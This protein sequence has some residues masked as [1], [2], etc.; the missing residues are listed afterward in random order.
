MCLRACA[1]LAGPVQWPK[2]EIEVLNLAGLGSIVIQDSSVGFR[3]EG[4]GLFLWRKNY[5]IWSYHGVWG[6]RGASS[7]LAIDEVTYGLKERL[8]RYYD[9]GISHA[10][11]MHDVSAFL[12]SALPMADAG[13]LGRGE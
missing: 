9:G 13:S 5:D 6:G 12:W 1:Y 10:E 8:A 11:S 4:A 2:Q 7:R 3:A